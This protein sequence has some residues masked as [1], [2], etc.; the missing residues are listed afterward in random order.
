[1]IV[2]NI[3]PDYDHSIANEPMRAHN[4]IMQNS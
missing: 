4:T 3:H 1:M 2:E